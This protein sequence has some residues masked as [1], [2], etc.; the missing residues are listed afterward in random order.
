[1]NLVMSIMMYLVQIIL[2]AVN[3]WIH[4]L[5]TSYIHKSWFYSD[6]NG[7]DN[8]NKNRSDVLILAE[9]NG[10]NKLKI[11]IIH[12]AIGTCVKGWTKTLQLYNNWF[13]ICCTFVSFEI[14]L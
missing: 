1:M 10:G 4:I 12:I 3:V 7:K 8:N 14:I 6:D 5:Y 2:S 11:M 13:I 9:I